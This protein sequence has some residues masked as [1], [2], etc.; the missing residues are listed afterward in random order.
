M[1][2]RTKKVGQQRKIKVSGTIPVEYFD[3]IQ[4]KIDSGEIYNMTHAIEKGI[5]ILMDDGKNDKN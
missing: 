3:W 4:D 1:M 5:C 2:G